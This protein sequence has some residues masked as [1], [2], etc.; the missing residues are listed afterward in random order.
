[1]SH[2]RDP[3][4]TRHESL[5]SPLFVTWASVRALLMENVERYLGDTYGG[6]ETIRLP[7]VQPIAVTLP[8]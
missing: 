4:I 6:A 2:A 7:D 3:I 5:F 1:M 8:W